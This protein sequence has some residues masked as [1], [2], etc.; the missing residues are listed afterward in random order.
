MSFGSHSSN[1]TCKPKVSYFVCE[2]SAQFFEENVL[3]F[4]VA[5]NEVFLM[6]ALEPFHDFNDDSDCLSE[7]KYFTW[8][9]GLIGKK[10]SLFTVFHDD[11]DKFGS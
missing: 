10:V 2:V 5:M 7:R 11:D 9:F 3:A 8:K 4:D 1:R 6:N